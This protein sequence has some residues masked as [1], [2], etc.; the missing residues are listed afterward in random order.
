M[1]L[2]HDLPPWGAV[3]RQ[4]RRWLAAGCFD[5]IVHDLREGLRLAQGRKPQPK[6]AILDGR[7]LQ[8]SCESEPEFTPGIYTT[9]TDSPPLS[10][11]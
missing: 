3:Y 9:L 8:S 10:L 5:A 7:T 2:P 6:A 1:M 4:T 11:P